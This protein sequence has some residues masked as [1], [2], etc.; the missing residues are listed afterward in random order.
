M[1]CPKAGVGHTD[2]PHSLPSYPPPNRQV[3]RLAR[4]NGMLAVRGNH[5]EAALAAFLAWLDGRGIAKPK[6]HFWVEQLEAGSGEL[7][8]ELPFTLEARP[9]GGCGV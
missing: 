2:S 5:D 8:R 7:L 6:K 4:A 1:R 9:R 3:L